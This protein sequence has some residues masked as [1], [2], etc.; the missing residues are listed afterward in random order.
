M[1]EVCAEKFENITNKD[2][3]QGAQAAFTA[4][5]IVYS[6]TPETDRGLRDIV[7]RAVHNHMKKVIDEDDGNRSILKDVPDLAYDLVC[8]QA[9]RVVGGNLMNIKCVCPGCNTTFSILNKSS[10]FPTDWM[11][12]DYNFICP[13]CSISYAT[14]RFASE[15][16]HKYTIP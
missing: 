13:A 16:H 3:E 8:T 12:V 10:K 9:S 7:V 1:P 11:D 14:D 15:F 2:Q 4:A 5:E 6:G